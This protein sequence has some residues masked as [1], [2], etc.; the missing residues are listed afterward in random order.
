VEPI[1]KPPSAVALGKLR[2]L[3][4][5]LYGGACRIYRAPGRVNLIGEHTDYNDGFVMP[6]ALDL[7]TYVAIGPRQ[8]RRLRVYSENL[9]EKVDFDLGAIRPGKTG[10]WSDYIRGVAGVLESSGYRLRGADLAIMSQVPLGSGLSSSAA[11]EVS[12]AYALLANSQLEIDCTTVAKLCQK[13]EHL[14]PETMC[15]IMDQFISCNGRAGH[16]LMLDC[17]SLDFQLLPVPDGVRLMVC[18]TMVRHEHASGGYNERRRECEEGLRALREV[19]PGIQSLRDVTLDELNRHR[20]RLSPVIYKRVRHVVTE[21]ERVKRAAS[22]LQTGDLALLGRLMAESHQSLRDDYEVSTPELD[23]MVELAKLQPEV[24]G[25]RMTGGGFGGC[26]I[27]LVDEDRAQEVHREIQRAYE[28]RTGVKPTILICR[29]SDGAGV[30]PASSQRM[31]AL[32]SSSHRRFNPLTREWVLVSP[33]RTD[34]PWQG[35]TEPQEQQS[36]QPYDPNCYLC[37]GNARSGG[38]RNPQYSQTFVFENDFAALRPDVPEMQIDVEGRGLLV[39]QTESGICRVVCFSPRHDLTLSRM[40]LPEIHK[41]IDVWVEEF[42]NLSQQPGLNYVQ[43][44]ENRGLMM[45]CSN[46]HPHGQIWATSTIPNEP[47]KEQEAF[48]DYKKQNG[49]CLLCDYINL[50]EASDERLFDGNDHFLAVVPFWA[51]WPFET[52]LVSKRHI[53]NMT[54]LDDAEQSAL[55]DI[56]KSVT[57]R[58]DN[59]CQAPCPYSMGFHQQPTDKIDHPEWHLHAHFFPPLL[60]SASVRKFMVGFEMLG[61]PQRDIT[62]EYAA[63]K[64]R[65]VKVESSP[66]KRT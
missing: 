66:D 21:N 20:D 33:H 11:L 10:H 31:S 46:P 42:Q 55:A 5:E 44:F 24:H 53:G 34:R 15:G 48:A 56:L 58:Y 52:L 30:I 35:Q 57:S 50:E 2:A 25:A 59:L 7:Y 64:L 62:P 65:E 28:A 39:A 37:P 61:S 23:L 51:T 47:R 32:Q 14:Y 43:I 16:A 18:N 9:G 12:T 40:S 63:E 19:L 6:V 38:L 29:A 1:D 60:R 22:A 27:T 8:D 49:S 4:V 54:A 36:T 13:A 17:R 26:T 41:V 3:F 45:G